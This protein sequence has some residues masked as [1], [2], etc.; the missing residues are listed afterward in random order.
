M[1]NWKLKYRKFGR[2][3]TMTNWLDQETACSLF[4]QMEKD[5][6]VSWCELI[7]A[8]ETDGDELIMD[9]FFR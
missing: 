3:A 5:L 6:S 7:Y 2:F 4:D 1:K 9:E 8:S